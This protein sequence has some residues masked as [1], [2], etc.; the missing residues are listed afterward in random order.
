MTIYLL[1]LFLISLYHFKGALFKLL[2]LCINGLL[3]VRGAVETLLSALTP[4]RHAKSH[5]NE[6][7]PAVMNADLLSRDEQNISLLLN[8]LVRLERKIY[9]RFSVFLPSLIHYFGSRRMT[10]MYY[11][12]LCNF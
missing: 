4:T 7:Q 8:L 2:I 3:K 9:S 11:I 12:T 6:V 1:S 10:S 5:S